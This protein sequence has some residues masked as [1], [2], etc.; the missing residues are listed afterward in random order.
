M[1]TGQQKNIK[2]TWAFC[3]FLLLLFIIPYSIV[4][5]LPLHRFTIPFI[6]G[7]ENIPFLPWTFIIYFSSFVQTLF[8]V[9]HLPKDLLF[10]SL[11]ILGVAVVS[12]LVFFIL[13][14]IRFP[15]EL[16]LSSN[17]FVKRF[18]IIDSDGNCFPSLHVAITIFF[19]YTWRLAEKN[20]ISHRLMWLWTFLIVTSVLTTKQHYLVDI[21]GGIAVAVICILIL[22]RRLHMAES[23]K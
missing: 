13:I 18:Q 3:F 2:T 14:P 22:K 21:F 10:Q 9:K 17:E 11:L 19:A 15:R 4:S 23:L 1:V 8:V 16:F 5:H 20:Y 12:C 7:E 6:L